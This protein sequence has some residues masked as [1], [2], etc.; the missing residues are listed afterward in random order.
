MKRLTNILATIIALIVF[1]FCGGGVSMSKCACTGRVSMV[2]PGD[3]GCCP[4]EGGCMT[5]TTLQVS[6]SEPTH[7]EWSADNMQLAAVCLVSPTTHHHTPLPVAHR[8]LHTAPYSPPGQTLSM[9]M[10]V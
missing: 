9:V 8:S 6:A 7:C 4:T 2:M 3:L 10:R 5:V 1:T